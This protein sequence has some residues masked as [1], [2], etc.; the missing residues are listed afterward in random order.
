[1]TAGGAAAAIASPDRHLRVLDGLRGAAVLLVVAYHSTYLTFPWGP[2]ILPGGF[3]GVDVFFA[4][5]GFLITRKLATDLLRRDGIDLGDFAVRR[6]RRLVPVLVVFVVATVAFVAALGDLPKVWPSDD[7]DWHTTWQSAA[8]ALTYTSNWMQAA[9]WPFMS[10]LSHTWSLAIEGQYYLVWPFVLL[11]LHRVRAPRPVILGLVG[12]VILWV[13]WHRADVW[14][15]Q[16]HYLS[17]YVGTDTRIDVLLAGSVLGLLAAWGDLR[18]SIGRWSLG[19]A[20]LGVVVL[21]VVS[22]LSE[23]GDHRLYDR[24][25]MVAVTLAAV[26]V[27]LDAVTNPAGPLG[28]TW[29]LPPLRWLGDRS[30]SLYLWHVPIFFAI[31][32]HLRT[33]P[34]PVK[35]LLGLGS[36]ILLSDLSFRFVEQRFRRRHRTS[37]AV[38]AST[39]T[40]A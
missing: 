14:V 6:A 35:V 18:P 2:R 26:A 36:S 20:L 12:L 34:T 16:A 21:G 7:T 29:S 11:A 27:V 13:W 22:C 5:S 8:G 25:G 15:D 24:Y 32:L 4:L 33:W 3:V 28:R 9:G 23:T 31:G 10:Q 19:P 38:P 39:P 1:M 37:A 30:Y 40:S 17:V